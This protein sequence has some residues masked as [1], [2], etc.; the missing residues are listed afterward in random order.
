MATKHA[1]LIGV[2]KYCNLDKKYELSGC[3]NDAQLVAKAL[4]YN[5]VAP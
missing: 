4:V 2:D 1:L 5:L 3:V